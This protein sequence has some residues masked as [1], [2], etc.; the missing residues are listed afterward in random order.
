MAIRP[1]GTPAPKQEKA[2]PAVVEAPPEADFSEIS[3]FYE[4][5]SYGMEIQE[6]TDT[7]AE[8]SEHVA[9][10]YANAGAA[11][12]RGMLESLVKGNNDPSAL[13]LWAMLFDLLRIQGER[14]AFDA[15]GM[16]FAK[17]CELSPPSWDLGVEHK[18]EADSGETGVASSV[19]LQGTIVGDNPL[20]GN[21]L[22]AM[23][24]GEA[25]TLDFGRLV[26][27]DGEAAAKLAKILNQVRRR[28]LAWELAGA[29]GLATRLANRAVTGQRQNESL[30]L[31][32]LEL[33]Q[34]LGQEAEFEEQALNYA[35][36]FEV[37]PP[38]WEVFKTHTAAKK[39]VSAVA[40]TKSTEKKLE[41][42]ARLEGEILQHDFSAIQP[43]LLP[44]K[45]CRLDFS[46][47]T[48]LD[49]VSAGALVELIRGSGCKAVIIYHPNRLVA[50]LMHITGVDQVASIEISKH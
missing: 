10:S 1:D 5:G 3:T 26:G 15:L 49:F 18:P 47:V 36:T 43:H 23:S 2:P 20:F 33:Y 12:V 30:W 17:V 27:L 50:E 34:F 7:F 24:K 13:K 11:S 29:A 25:R 22:Q 19:A 42:A 4:G 38:A 37:S 16:E 40:P 48:R 28:G 6:E 32:L 14:K 35:I 9:I 41:V 31:L 8:M 46:G 45:E 21:L 39:A 44:G